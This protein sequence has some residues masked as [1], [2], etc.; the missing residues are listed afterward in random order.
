[1]HGD[2]GSRYQ[3]VEVRRRR[4]FPAVLSPDAL[5]CFSI[6]VV[7]VMFDL[8]FWMLNLLF[9]LSLV[10]GFWVCYIRRTSWCGKGFGAEQTRVGFQNG[11]SCVRASLS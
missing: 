11:K 6:R 3:A 9:S 5:P 1:M 7:F 10:Q 4:V 2:A 8:M